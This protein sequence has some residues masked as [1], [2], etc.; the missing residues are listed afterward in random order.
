M[1]I[2]IEKVK[3][4]EQN[5]KKWKKKRRITRRG[6]ENNKKGTEKGN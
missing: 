4:K 1:E 3:E 2:M 6:G 5:M